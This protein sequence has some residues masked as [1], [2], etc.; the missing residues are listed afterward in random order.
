MSDCDQVQPVSSDAG[1]TWT[2]FRDA[3]LKYH[4]I[5]G[6]VKRNSISKI[7]KRILFERVPFLTKKLEQATPDVL[8]FQEN[9]MIKQF[10][11]EDDFT[12][13]YTCCVES[14]G[15][16]AD[17]AVVDE[18]LTTSGSPP[19]LPPLLPPWNIHFKSFTRLKLPYLNRTKRHSKQSKL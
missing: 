4:K 16:V 1:Q 17:R 8:T 14:N 2:T 3:F 15:A 12:N 9:D 13:R 19:L 7:D 6:L 10:L 5:E 11:D 18:L